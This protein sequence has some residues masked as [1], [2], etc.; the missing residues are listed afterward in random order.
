MVQKVEANFSKTRMGK[1][2]V[3]FRSKMN[4]EASSQ[5]P[6]TDIHMLLCQGISH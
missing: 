1:K 2:G 5:A 3:S 4:K 6:G